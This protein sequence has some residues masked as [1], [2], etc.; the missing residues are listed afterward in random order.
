MKKIYFI[1]ILLL[2]LTREVFAVPVN[3]S[4]RLIESEPCIIN[5]SQPIQVDF[6]DELI[7]AKVPTK[8]GNSYNKKIDFKWECN[9]ISS[10]TDVVFSFDGKDSN[11]DIELLAI[12]EQDDIALQLYNGNKSLKLNNDFIYTY[13][14]DNLTPD[15]SAS[16]VKSSSSLAIVYPGAF[17][18]SAT[19]T[20]AYQ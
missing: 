18:A 13:I 19:L 8:D 3:F 1:T 15:L 12:N 5:N 16:L 9:G 11:F 14:S 6:G 17:T 20:V 7:V 10:G 4:G 2:L